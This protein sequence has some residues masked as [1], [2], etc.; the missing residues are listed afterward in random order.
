MR[1]FLLIAC[2]EQRKSDAFSVI[3]LR[4][5]GTDDSYIV[6]SHFR[7]SRWQFTYKEKLFYDMDY[8]YVDLHVN[9]AAFPSYVNLFSKSLA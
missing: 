7:G 1:E 5:E 3:N 9:Q 6:N 2:E 4:V 8:C